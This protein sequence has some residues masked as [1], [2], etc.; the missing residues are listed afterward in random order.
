MRFQSPEI[1]AN[2]G[3]DETGAG[4]HA[5]TALLEA[6]LFGKRTSADHLSPR[7]EGM[8]TVPD[9]TVLSPLFLIG[10][11]VAIEIVGDH[12]E[13]M[14]EAIDKLEGTLNDKR[15]IGCG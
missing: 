10:Q 2:H 8:K 3:E 13:K 7:K 6:N 5:G 14:G 11:S 4:S 1:T 15:E 12:L 9:S